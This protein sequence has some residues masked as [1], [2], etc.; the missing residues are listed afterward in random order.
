M[1]VGVRNRLLLMRIHLTTGISKFSKSPKIPCNINGQH[2][3][4]FRVTQ[5][6]NI[7]RNSVIR[8][9]F[10]HRQISGWDGSPVNRCSPGEGRVMYTVAGSKDTFTI[11]SLH[12]R[13]NFR[14]ASPEPFFD[15]VG[16]LEDLWDCPPFL[17]NANILYFSPCKDFWFPSWKKFRQSFGPAAMPLNLGSGN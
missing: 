14:Y 2:F 17:A 15:K 10:H 16:R 8:W 3:A 1:I 6:D 5:L 12:I 4:E 13:P 9:L 7:S 11:L